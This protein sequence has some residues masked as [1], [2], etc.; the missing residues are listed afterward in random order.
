MRAALIAVMLIVAL[1]AFSSPATTEPGP[2][3]RWLM[4]TPVSLWDKGMF[5][6]AEAAKRAAKAIEAEGHGAYTSHSVRYD[7]NNNEIIFDFSV[8]RFSGAIQHKNCN[9]MRRAF[10]SVL[11]GGAHA[12]GSSNKYS[13]FL[14]HRTVG[15]W[16]SHYGYQSKDRDKR[17]AEK[18]SRIIFVGTVIVN[19]DAG[20]VCKD[21]ITVLDAPSRPCEVAS[22]RRTAWRLG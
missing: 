2:I 20:I 13:R 5:A 6:A 15:Q 18:L 3:G 22:V 1:S 21:R 10:I 7:W 17:L 12:G 4:N 11:T 14:I 8:L 16:F 9:L 19:K